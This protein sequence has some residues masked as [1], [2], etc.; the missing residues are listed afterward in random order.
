MQRQA[1]GWNNSADLLLWFHFWFSSTLLYPGSLSS[2]FWDRETGCI[3][4][5]IQIHVR[6]SSGLP[7]RLLEAFSFSWKEKPKK[8]TEFWLSNFRSIS[9]PPQPGNKSL[10]ERYWIL[11]RTSIFSYERVILRETQ[12]CF[13]ENSPQSST[14]FGWKLLQLFNFL[15][16]IWSW[17][18]TWLW[19]DTDKYMRGLKYCSNPHKILLVE[20]LFFS[21]LKLEPRVN[22]PPA[23]RSWQ[24]V[25]E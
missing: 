8:E 7:T 11:C 14:D 2:G 4:S 25:D 12:M 10:K 20:F 21:S 23:G 6:S 13:A 19:S 3:I 16:L 24:V 15:T 9:A 18:P 1:G 17:M 22:F 5:E